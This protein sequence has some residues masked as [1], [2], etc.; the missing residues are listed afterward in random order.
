MPF[1][2]L[3]GNER[4][5]KLLQRAVAE[6]RIGQ[7]LV[8]AGPRG[9]GKHQFAIA[10]AQALNCE[11]P[12]NGDACGE[13]L[14]CRK[15]AA[16][17]HA[18]V[19]TILRE[20]QDPNVKKDYKSQFIKIDQM[21]EMSEQAQFRPYE[22]LRR[23]YI[24]DEAEWLREEAANAILKTLEEPPATTLIILITS[25]PYALLETIRSRCLMLS[26]APLTADELEAYLKANY[27]RPA[28]ETR[29]LA[30]LARGSIGR[31]LEIDLGEYREKRARMIEI[32]ES[33]A[34]RRDTLKLMEAAEYLG[35]KLEKSEFE[36]HL[37]ALLALLADLFHLKLGESA[38][39]ITNAD[40]AARL[41]K[42]REAMT[43]EQI[44]DLV[45][46][47][48][49]ILQGLARNV[50]RQLAMESALVTA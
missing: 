39:R 17:E 41:E 4:I 33:L 15:I 48:E 5:K 1:S 50:N 23:V 6:G 11:R 9:V 12:V 18:D 46:R 34:L 10:L 27:K 14:Q 42:I 40:A 45:G 13:C 36:N 24:I 19:R 37:D 8:M 16:R 26:F 32:I 25:K 38:D 35:K 31:A 28:E 49:E 3:I 20:S 21:R 2:S 30:R 43:L 47:I 7:S 29:M 44:I 22:G